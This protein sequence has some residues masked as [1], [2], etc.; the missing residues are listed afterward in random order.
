MKRLEDE[1]EE[2]ER[3]IIELSKEVEKDRQIEMTAS[4]KRNRKTAFWDEMENKLDDSDDYLVAP[5]KIWLDTA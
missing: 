4:R 2:K 3:E 1:R 5:N